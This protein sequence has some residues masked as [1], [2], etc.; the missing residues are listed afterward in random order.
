MTA[1][2]TSTIPTA[3]DDYNAARDFGQSYKYRE[4]IHELDHKHDWN[5]NPQ[6]RLPERLEIA[7]PE[8]PVV[9][10]LYKL[11]IQC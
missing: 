6:S 7:Q 9:E 8:Q 5:G 3:D 2:L 4:H 10:F 11:I 1:A